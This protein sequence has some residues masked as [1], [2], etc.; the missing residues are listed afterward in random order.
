MVLV[1]AVREVHL[2]IDCFQHQVVVWVEIMQ[3]QPLVLLTLVAVEAE[4]VG[5]TQVHLLVPQVVQ[6]MHELLI[7]VN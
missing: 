4:Q 5:L 6:V 2:I 3:T 1:A 7:G